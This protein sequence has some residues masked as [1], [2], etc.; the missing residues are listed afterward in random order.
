M[1]YF[2]GYSLATQL[3]S[4]GDLETA[5][6]E[7]F[8]NWNKYGETDLHMAFAKMVYTFAAQAL[9]SEFI[10]ELPNF[11]LSLSFNGFETV[12]EVNRVLNDYFIFDS[13]NMALCPLRL[14]TALEGSNE[15]T[16]I[17]MAVLPTLAHSVK[18]LTMFAFVN[19]L[20]SGLT[21]VDFR[22]FL[23]GV[24]IDIQPS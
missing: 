22:D 14:S 20:N 13:A 16:N 18:E 15:Y 1:P 5:I 2:E 4:E 21:E 12:V 8:R 10:S 19:Y 3:K 23:L 11:K 6:T 17:E 24:E 7:R 9:G